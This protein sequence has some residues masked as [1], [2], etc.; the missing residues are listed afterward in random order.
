MRTLQ[1]IVL[2]LVFAVI[3]PQ[4]ALAATF[5]TYDGFQPIVRAFKAIALIFASNDIFTIAGVASAVGVFFVTGQQIYSAMSGRG[6]NL[7]AF[8][9]PVLGIALFVA[10]FAPDEDVIVYDVRTNQTETVAEVPYAISQLACSINRIERGVVDLI[11]TVYS[12]TEEAAGAFSL[13]T[14]M[15]FFKAANSNP[16]LYQNTKSYIADCVMFEALRPGTTLSVETLQSNADFLPELAKAANMAIY[17][18][19]YDAA[20]PGGVATTCNDSWSNATYGLVTLFNDNATFTDQV[21]SACG[22]AKFN[23]GDSNDIA[24]CKTLVADMFDASSPLTVSGGATVEKLLRHALIAQ[25]I[26]EVVSESDTASAMSYLAVRDTTTKGM[27]TFIAANELLPIFKAGL[28][29]VAI[30]LIPFIAVFIASSLA[31]RALSTILGIFI[32]LCAWGITDAIVTASA[33][34]FINDMLETMRKGQLGLETMLNFPDYA[35]KTASV[36]GGLRATAMGIAATIAMMLVRSGGPFLAG[37]ASNIAG[38]FQSSGAGAGAVATP[39]GHTQMMSSMVNA[40]GSSGWMAGNEF[41]TMAN[42]GHFDKQM[43]TARYQSTMAAGHNMGYGSIESVAMASAGA[44]MQGRGVALLN[45]DGSEVVHQNMMPNGESAMTTATGYGS[46]ESW[47]RSRSGDFINSKSSFGNI[48][49]HRD[50][51]GNESADNRDLALMN[52]SYSTSSGAQMTEQGAS[53]MSGSENWSTGVS[54]ALKSSESNQ[55]AREFAEQYRQ[56]EAYQFMAGMESSEG[57]Q[58]KTMQYLRK[59]YHAGADVPKMLQMA[60]GLSAGYDAQAGGGTATEGTA[61]AISKDLQQIQKTAENASTEAIK[62]TFSNSSVREGGMQIAE[63]SGL[64]EEAS[65]VTSGQTMQSVGSQYNAN[66]ENGWLKHEAQQE[67]GTSTPSLAQEEKTMERLANT[68]NNGSVKEQQG[69]QQSFANYAKQFTDSNSVTEGAQGRQEQAS[70]NASNYGAEATSEN[71]QTVLGLTKDKLQNETASDIAHGQ[72]PV[73]GNQR[74]IEDKE[75]I[76]ARKEEVAAKK[77][78][79]EDRKGEVSDSATDALVRSAMGGAIPK[80]ASVGVPQEGSIPKGKEGYNVGLS[81]P[82]SKQTSD[83]EQANLASSPHTSTLGLSSSEHASGQGGSSEQPIGQQG[84][85]VQGGN[86]SEQPMGQAHGLGKAEGSSEQPMGQAHGLNAPTGNNTEQPMGQAHGMGQGGSS[87]ETPM[88]QTHGVGQG[89]GPSETPMGQ[90]HG[91]GKSGDSGETPMG[92][93]H[94]GNEQGGGSPSQQPSDHENGLSQDANSSSRHDSGSA[95]KGEVANSQKPEH[96]NDDTKQDSGSKSD[97]NH[98]PSGQ[99]IGSN[100]SRGDWGNQAEN[101]YNKSLGSEKNDN[102]EKA[103]GGSSSTDPTGGLFSMINDYYDKG[104]HGEP[105]KY[106]LY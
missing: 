52:G 32:F 41:S 6:V 40:A 77:S 2:A 73:Q 51:M 55:D 47:A 22:R 69:V 8:F 48:F 63:R 4:S 19:R 74:N 21:E 61:A 68:L 103:E 26:Y 30:G 64:S 36:Y 70:G 49:G 93:A 33:A 39:E 71:S 38:Q 15:E 99:S 7:A 101:P 34:P 91:S 12:G 88:G 25:T 75:D 35:T 72:S 24:V 96:N 60:T 98:S 37:A 11:E 85:V 20:N 67:W 29:S 50:S 79:T 28:M 81:V 100:S 31:G 18:T 97:T 54:A 1:K 59:A 83:A 78:V 65:M 95:G 62:Q 90:A 3:A 76:Q 94:G 56:A 13:L 82:P 53:A 42:Q 105:K 57:V 10:L 27:G 86:S 87:S 45:S 106:G 66:L 84:N 104:E 92:Q 44:G 5:Y 14:T 16:F 17:T 23:S 80:D 58:E 89:G 9:P 46:S 102:N 43:G